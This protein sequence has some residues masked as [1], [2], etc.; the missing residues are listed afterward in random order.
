MR[1]MADEN[2]AQADAPDTN[3]TLGT[4]A[5][6]A[7]TGAV[8]SNEK[9]N[10]DFAER[11]AKASTPDELARLTK[12]FFARGDTPAHME[13]KEDGESVPESSDQPAGEDAGAGK[14]EGKP[15]ASKVEEEESEEEDDETGEEAAQSKRIRVRPKADD[16]VGFRALEIQRRNRDLTLEECVARARAELGV[17][18]EPEADAKKPE[19][20]KPDEGPATVEEADTRIKD[21]RA[22]RRKALTEDFDFEKAAD[23]DDQ[24]DALKD[25]RA[26]LVAGDA[27]AKDDA[28]SEYDA[29]FDA[30]QSKAAEL[31]DFVR[32]ANGAE[33]KRMLEIDARLKDSGD[34]LYSDPEK[35]LILAR[36]VAREF[37]I[38]P[39]AKTSTKPAPVARQA[40]AKPKTVAPIASGSSRT[41]STAS[42]TAGQQLLERA[43]RIKSPG[44][45]EE[46]LASLRP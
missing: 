45:M 14:D 38:A 44:E 31:Y 25:R 40:A 35:P 6:A 43:A 28:A 33:A 16:K 41:A 22:Q 18:P 12:E 11:V 17:K 26:A 37:H 5:N 10:D 7:D 21:L 4:D 15:E 3:E 27:K 42:N 24:I 23:L 8:H 34:P 39:K 30:A 36:M 46:F 13:E 32:D 2:Q 9:G 20:A 19:E 29:K 1:R